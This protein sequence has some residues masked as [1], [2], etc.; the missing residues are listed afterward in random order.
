MITECQAGFRKNYSTV[1]QIFNLYAI[2]QKCLIK[3]GQ[4]LYMAFV[5]FKRGFD[6]VHC[7]KLLEFI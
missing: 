4:K 5:D 3:K 6:S 7:D 1:D 2:V